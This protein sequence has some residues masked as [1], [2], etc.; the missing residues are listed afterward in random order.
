[1]IDPHILVTRHDGIVSVEL[2]RRDKKNA[3]TTGMYTALGH[4]FDQAAT[5]DDVAVVLLHGQSDLFTAGNDLTDFLSPAARET[6]AAQQ[7]LQAIS[8]FPK[9][10]VAAIG[11]PAIGIGTT[12][13][14]HCDFVIAAEGARLQ[15]PF[16]QLGLCPEAGSSMLLPQMAGHRLAAELMLLG[17]PF[18][19]VKAREAGIVTT[20]VPESALLAHSHSLAQ[21]LAR[22]PRDAMRTTKALL[23]RPLGRTVTE[24]MEEEYPYFERLLVSNEA[25]AIFRAFLEKRSSAR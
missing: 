5:D 23:K 4:A 13:L 22:Q 10:I 16:V 25:R 12:M 6:R 21:R 14:M 20:I 9:P 3:I 11:G 1:M 18:D 19:A 17:E 8:C 24:A 7:F 15:L 2:S